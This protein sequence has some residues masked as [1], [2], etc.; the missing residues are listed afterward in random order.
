MLRLHRRFDDLDCS[1]FDRLLACLNLPEESVITLSA[2][3]TMITAR[4]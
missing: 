1:R 4:K 3:A 2:A